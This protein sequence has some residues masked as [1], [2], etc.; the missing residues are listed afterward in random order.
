MP[1]YLS[2]GWGGEDAAA[3][4]A[5]AGAGGRVLSLLFL[6]IRFFS[7]LPDVASLDPTSRPSS[8]S[9]AGRYI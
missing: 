3:G 4:D 5:A 1:E 8:R 9:S 6:D 7:F 2:F